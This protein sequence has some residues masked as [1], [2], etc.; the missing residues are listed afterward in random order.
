MII[1]YNE[2]TE[3]VC[4]EQSKLITVIIRFFFFKSTFL[5]IWFQG[6]LLIFNETD[7]SRFS[8][9]VVPEMTADSLN[10]FL[11]EQ[12]IKN[13]PE[14]TGGFPGTDNHKHRKVHKKVQNT[15]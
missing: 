3:A 12:H 10:A 14:V 15:R 7:L 9:T 8:L 4:F 1:F 2:P 13:Q 6:V 5:I 11:S